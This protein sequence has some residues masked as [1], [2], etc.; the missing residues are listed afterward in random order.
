MAQPIAL[1][2]EGAGLE[3]GA[4]RAVEDDD[5]L[6]NQ[7]EEGLTRCHKLIGILGFMVGIENWQRRSTLRSRKSLSFRMLRPGH[8]DDIIIRTCNN[9]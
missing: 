5:A 1:E 6:A 8:A 2:V 7:I 9:C 4:H 3:V